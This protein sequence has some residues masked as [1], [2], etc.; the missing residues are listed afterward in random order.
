MQ[1]CCSQEN[2]CMFAF[3]INILHQTKKK[4]DFHLKKHSFS[5]HIYVYI[6]TT[7]FRLYTKAV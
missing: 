1:G 3:P 4:K 2:T 7:F 5:V 6:Y